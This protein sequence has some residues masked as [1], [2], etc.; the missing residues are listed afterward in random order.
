MNV[1]V[2]AEHTNGELEFELKFG[3]SDDLLRY[4][5]ARQER[6]LSLNFHIED[7]DLDIRIRLSARRFAMRPIQ[8]S[9]SAANEEKASEFCRDVVAVIRSMK[10]W[11]S[12]LSR[13]PGTL[14][15]SLA[16]A[17]LGLVLVQ[18]W[19]A[20]SPDE[21]RTGAWA[22]ILAIILNLFRLMVFPRGAFVLSQEPWWHIKGQPLLSAGT[23]AALVSLLALFVGI[24]Q[25][26][27][28]LGS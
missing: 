12:P 8:V 25:W 5:R 1:L 4:I 21:Y 11:Y 16:T 26:I 2:S 7:H 15:G 27:F 22:L 14:H 20:S 17:L 23:F 6:L 3:E 10:P 19:M 24:A 9:V 13:F 28:C 18:I